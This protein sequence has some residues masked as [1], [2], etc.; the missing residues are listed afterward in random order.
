MDGSKKMVS[1]AKAT[2]RG[3]NFTFIQ[4]TFEDYISSEGES[5]KYDMVFSSNAIHHLTL[6]GKSKMYSRIF[7]ELTNGGLFIN[8]DVVMPPSERIEDWEFR[9]WVDWIN[10]TLV[11]NNQNDE[12][13][14][15]DGVPKNY[16]DAHENKPDDLFE[17]LELLRKIGFKNVE[18]FYKYG[19]FTMFG[20][21]K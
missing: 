15:Y 21:T 6:I 5:L 4:K 9:M 18:C 10:E 3:D 2:L 19:I 20:G 11:R 12:I 14:K 13:G 17:Q 7:H 16:K 1:K 8:I